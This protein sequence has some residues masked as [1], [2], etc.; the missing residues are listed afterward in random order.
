MKIFGIAG[1]SGSGK[2]TL[3]V[4]LIP[5]LTV[6]GLTVS[7][8]K[9]AHHGFDIDKPGKDSF[10]HRAA[11][12]TEVMIGAANRWALMHELHGGPEPDLDE[13]VNQMSAV[14]L[15]L[16]EGFKRYP[17]PKIEV[18]HKPLG[19]ALLQPDD[20]SIIAVASVDKF[21]GLAVPWLDVND[22]NMISGFILDQC[23]LKAA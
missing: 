5:A 4:K 3:I 7:T 21:D 12:A 22:V 20:P 9:H 23:D 19:K 1:W 11:G 6:Q 16:V 17:H 13:L 2:T 14:D 15:L 8:M 18:H 10:E